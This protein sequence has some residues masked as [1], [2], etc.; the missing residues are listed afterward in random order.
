[1]SEPRHCPHCPDQ[2]WYESYNPLFGQP[3]VVQC[4]FCYT[5]EDSVFNSSN[6]DHQ[7]DFDALDTKEGKSA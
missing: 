7:I 6:E 5:Q 2:G 4:A 1:M 3:T